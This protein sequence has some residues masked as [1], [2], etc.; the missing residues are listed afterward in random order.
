MTR[1]IRLNALDMMCM[2]ATPGIWRHPRD[3]SRGYNT[4]EYW[5]DLARTLER[6]LFDSI[7]IADIYGVYDV[8]SGN[9]D[10]AF[11]HAVEFPVCD[12]ML[13]VPAMAMVTEH[14]GFGV[15]STLTYEP[16]YSFARRAATLDHLTNGRFAWNIVTGY[17]ESAARGFGLTEQLSHDQRYDFG[18][19]YLQVLY[20]L[21]EGSWEDDAI[22]NDK[23]AGV[24]ADAGKIHRI[25]HHGK[26]LDME[27]YQLCEPSPQR[28]PVL[29]QAGASGRGRQFAATHA[30][31]VF[32]AGL[33]P[34]AT[35]RT[36]QD[37]R[38]RAVEQGRAGHDL[39]IYN[40]LALV[41][42]ETDAE[43]QAKLED[44]REHVD[45]EGSLTLFAG[46]TGIDFAGLDLDHPLRYF[47]SN[48]IRS[49]V[50]GFTV[51]DPDREWTLRE[52]AKFLGVGGFAPIAVGSPATLADIMA[53]WMAE[54]DIDGFNL[55]YSVTPDDFE[56][57][58]NLVVP[59]LQ[60]RGLYR[61]E[62]APGT[63]RAKLT[64]AG[65]NHLPASHPAACY[66][67]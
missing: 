42:G 22:I 48:A 1:Q 65:R 9:A 60:R 2:G 59:E 28:T 13:T 45:I 43:A 26:Y 17:L 12:P 34:A 58:V 52:I 66:R 67:R 33:T 35:A 18:D 16:V 57:V 31:C 23:Q 5:T 6:G 49:F 30:E 40:A 24:F 63:L 25:E 4:L 56:D 54:T 32:T 36:V 44:Y 3:R 61:H 55:L 39:I 11:T 29:F 7:F 51:A 46:Y 10:S 20:K 15:T 64:G 21:W 50:E 19:E 62:Y 27:G 8:F 47:E 53:H 37:L 38:A 14:L 41:C